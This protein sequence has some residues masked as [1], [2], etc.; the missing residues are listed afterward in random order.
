MINIGKGMDFRLV[1][2]VYSALSDCLNKRC[3]PIE[4]AKSLIW[5]R[6]C[7][8][9]QANLVVLQTLCSGRNAPFASREKF[10]TVSGALRPKS[11]VC[12]AFCNPV[13]RECTLHWLQNWSQVRIDRAGSNRAAEL[14]IFP[15]AELLWGGQTWLCP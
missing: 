12:R 6:V 2:K 8:R 9:P 5:R 13:G 11:I 14:Q 3:R 1:G 15:A 4:S 10:D 7:S